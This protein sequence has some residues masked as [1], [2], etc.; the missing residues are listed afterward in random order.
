MIN[1]YQ[2]ANHQ[3]TTPSTTY[4]TVQKSS[5]FFCPRVCV[6]VTKMYLEINGLLRLLYTKKIVS[7]MRS[8]NTHSHEASSIVK[9]YADCYVTFVHAWYGNMMLYVLVKGCLYS[10]EIKKSSHEN[11]DS[12]L[13]QQWWTECKHCIPFIPSIK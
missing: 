12:S 11:D 13:V 9:I 10:P 3:A 8:S 2:C 1:R 6:G 5:E 4:Y 7:D